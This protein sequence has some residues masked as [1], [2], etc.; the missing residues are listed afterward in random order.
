MIR[1][2]YA[3]NFLS[4]ETLDASLPLTGLVHI[5]GRVEGSDVS[6]SNGAGKT[7]ILSLIRWVLFGVNDRGNADDVIKKGSKGG[8]VGRVILL[9][10]LGHELRITRYRKHK[11]HKN[12]LHVESLGAPGLDLTGTDNN[13][14]QRIID[15]RLGIDYNMF[16][17]GFVFDGSLSIARMKD[18][19]A[20][21][22]FEKLIGTD[23]SDKH[24]RAK[25]VL[26][27]A[28]SA[29]ITARNQA[30]WIAGQAEQAQQQI[31][32]VDAQEQEW[33]AKQQPAIDAAEKQYDDLD[34]ELAEFD[35]RPTEKVAWWQQKIKEFEAEMTK[36]QQSAF[37]RQQLEIEA[38]KVGGWLDQ[39]KQQNML[40]AACGAP[41][42]GGERDKQIAELQQQ[43]QELKGKLDALPPAKDIQQ[44]NKHYT[45]LNASLMK[46]QQEVTQWDHAW[47]S[48]EQKQKQLKEHIAA[49]KQNPFPAQREAAVANWHQKAQ[50]AA[51]A[52]KTITA[53]ERHVENCQIMVD[54]FSGK[55]LRSFILDTIVPHLNARLAYYSGIVT[56]GEISAAFNTTTKTG[57]EKFHITVSRSKGGNTYES[58]SQG[59]KSRLDLCLILALHEYLRTM[60]GAPLL[61]FDELM[62]GL[63]ATGTERVLGILKAIAQD[64]QVIVISHNPHVANYT[65]HVLTVVKQ[66]GIS[67]IES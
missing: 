67:R 15:E 41:V 50:Q 12:A 9:D 46:A 32:T 58:L 38:S 3:E 53:H 66:D 52:E 21:D 5:Y 40:C 20:K 61:F 44:T 22:F 34:V 26:A 1:R 59:E 19:E 7:A 28:N 48:I 23:F 24:S 16:Q 64:T 37:E 65:D 30:Q 47:H 27:D 10:K 60:V 36:A 63:D 57:K 29:M 54:M 42:D 4:F 43:A 25:A 49:L 33:L 39:L 51:D 35:Q 2:V 8:T 18:T 62:D 14:T 55:G 11:E 56:G 17:R 31:A 13:D 6:D 45:E